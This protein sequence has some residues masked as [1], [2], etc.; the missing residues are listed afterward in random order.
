MYGAGIDSINSFFKLDNK[1]ENKLFTLMARLDRL[2]KI[3]LNETTSKD[4]AVYKLK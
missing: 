1:L 2:E 4:V 3:A